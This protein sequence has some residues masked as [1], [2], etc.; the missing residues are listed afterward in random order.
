MSGPQPVGP[1]H[2]VQVHA[3][4]QAGLNPAEFV[5]LKVE[6]LPSL[7]GGQAAD[8]S[9]VMQLVFRLPQNVVKYPSSL[10]PPEKR[11]EEL[12]K[13]LSMVMVTGELVV[14]RDAIQPAA[15]EAG[16]PVIA[17]PKADWS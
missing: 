11:F 7:G 2:P 12:V 9:F 17:L 3:L 16:E 6:A 13:G 14:K 5:A 10:L 4:M 8:G 1:L 15:L